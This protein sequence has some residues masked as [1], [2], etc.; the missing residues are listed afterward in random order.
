M[1]QQHLLIP[2]LR[3]A[4]ADAEAISHKLLLRGGFI[5]QLASGVYSFLP[6]GHKVLAKVQAIV[7]EEMERAGVQE[8]LLPSLQPAE[9][10]QQSGRYEHYGPLLIRLQD[11]GGRGFVLGP[12]HEEA[13]TA[14]IG[15]EIASYRQLPFSVF[16]LQT[17]FRD[18][19]RPKSGLLRCREFI[20][21]DAYSFSANEEELAN[22]YEA[23]YVAYKR[24]FERCG[25]QYRAV[26][27]DAGSI[28]GSGGSHEFMALS[29]TGEDTIMACPGCGYAANV[30]KAESAPALKESTADK[31]KV[32][33]S[34]RWFTPQ[35]K[36]IR[37]LT[38]AHDLPPAAFIKTLL[39]TADGKLIAV[40]MRGDSEA[41]EAK[42][43][44]LL[45]AASL[46][47]AS[48]EQV[49]AAVGAPIGFVGPVNLPLMQGEKITIIAD[50]HAAEMDEAIV[51]ANEPD[52]HLKHVVPERD[53]SIALVGDLRTAQAGEVCIHCS[54]PL[55]AI[56]GIEVGHIFKLGDKYSEPLKTYFVDREG[57]ERPIVMGCYGIGV[58]RLLAAIIEQSHDE[59][60]MIWPQ[61]IAPFSVHLILMSAKDERQRRI[62]DELYAC[63]QA[64]GIATLYDDRTERPGVKLKEADLI[65]LP[66]RVVVGK[67]AEEGVVELKARTAMMEKVATS[68]LVSEIQLRLNNRN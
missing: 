25:L 66:L 45:G 48:A 61:E 22:Q 52:Y 33:E 1:R 19:R 63:L 2:T 29:D 37:E 24:I 31:A 8:I 38:A 44:T 15:G 4:P 49:L 21:K 46:E 42:I 51:G 43:K 5:R 18:E 50:R 68:Q 32:P 60:G 10:W 34:E 23:M 7:R 12:T 55:E 59:H 26:E 41:N 16:Q 64:E 62:A 35:L 9:L 36:S 39:Y 58:T 65:G 47:L 27:A 54:T 53:F 6:L 67:A 14:L 17:K 40:L 28:G 11:R 20:M 30:E 13:V 57:R 3:E 56:K